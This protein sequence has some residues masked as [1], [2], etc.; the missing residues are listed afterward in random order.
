MLFCCCYVVIVLC[1]SK[2]L[3]KITKAAVAALST[4]P[5]GA[6]SLLPPPATKDYLEKVRKKKNLVAKSTLSNVNPP[7]QFCDTRLTNR[8]NVVFLCTASEPAASR[9]RK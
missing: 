1:R 8:H 4:L 2:L 7:Q 5:Q 9:E 3:K 6:K